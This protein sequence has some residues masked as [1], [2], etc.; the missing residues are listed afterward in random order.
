LASLC[1]STSPL[2]PA[3]P[4][5][6][7]RGWLTIKQA[8]S[9]GFPSSRWVASVLRSSSSPQPLAASAPL[10]LP[11]GQEDLVPLPR[12]ALGFR[13]T[14]RP[15]GSSSRSLHLA[16]GRLHRPQPLASLLPRRP[17]RGGLLLPQMPSVSLLLRGALEPSLLGP[18][19][20]APRHL[21]L[22][23]PPRPLGSPP[24]GPL[25]SRPSLLL[26]P[27]LGAGLAPPCSRRRRS[28]QA[29]ERLLLGPNRAAAAPLQQ[30]AAPSPQPLAAFRLRLPLAR[31]LG[32]PHRALGCPQPC[33]SAGL[34]LPRLPLVLSEP[35]SLAQLQ[36]VLD[37]S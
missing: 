11:Q 31:R 21:E 6:R 17:L 13:Q 29:L 30:W 14:R 24:Q 25:D 23:P 10:P 34:R 37:P 26:P 12:R 15:L 8:G 36:A 20:L 1:C 22:R 27:P 2:T 28:V 33:L 7:R 16:S 5:R 18:L 3:R 32:S 4:R 35:R 19:P 9:T